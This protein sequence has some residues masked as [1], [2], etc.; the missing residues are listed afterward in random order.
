MIRASIICNG[1]QIEDTYLD[2]NNLKEEV[3]WFTDRA[4]PR[5]AYQFAD[6]YI[7]ALRRGGDSVVRG[8]ISILLEMK[9]VSCAV[10]EVNFNNC[11]SFTETLSDLERRIWNWLLKEVTFSIVHSQRS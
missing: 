11:E 10:E 8:E 7:T 6:K 2:T 1:Y 4:A 5:V 9:Y 3:R